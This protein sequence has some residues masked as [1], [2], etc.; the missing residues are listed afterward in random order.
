MGGLQADGTTPLHLG[1]HP[2]LGLCDLLGQGAAG[3]VADLRA[4]DALAPQ[5][6]LVVGAVEFGEARA[7]SADPGTFGTG[8]RTGEP[9][10]EKTDE[11][12]LLC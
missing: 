5:L 11:F 7:Q 3:R 8:L 9:V 6:L 10:L 2:G 1:A 4:Q 12:L